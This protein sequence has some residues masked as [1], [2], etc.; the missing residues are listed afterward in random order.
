[1]ETYDADGAFHQ[2]CPSV[3][4][5]VVMRRAHKAASH[6]APAAPWQPY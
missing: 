3:S 1:M 2:A 4:G 5:A 6:R